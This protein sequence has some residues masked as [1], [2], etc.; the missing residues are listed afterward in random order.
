MSPR[1]ESQPFTQNIHGGLL[2]LGLG[3]HFFHAF[4]EV[5][6]ET[7]GRSHCSLNTI[8]LAMVGKWSGTMQLHDKP[9]T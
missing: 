2:A 1:L 5:R 6:V 3:L 8:Q 9:A 7:N 4:K